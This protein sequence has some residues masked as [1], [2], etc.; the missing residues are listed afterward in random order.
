MW[1]TDR[2][3]GGASTEDTGETAEWWGVGSSTKVLLDG[4]VSFLNI[5]ISLGLAGDGEIADRR[6][7]GEYVEQSGEAGWWKGNGGECT[8]SGLIGEFL[9]RSEG[10]IG[11]R[12]VMRRRKADCGLGGEFPGESSKVDK[13]R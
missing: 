8:D 9:L 11:W 3:A 12:E 6:S 7:G 13:W 10:G 4:L 5:F 2:G 1:K